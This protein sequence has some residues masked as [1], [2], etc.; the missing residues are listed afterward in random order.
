V[1]LVAESLDQ[2]AYHVGGEAVDK[3]PGTSGAK[4]ALDQRSVV[5]VQQGAAIGE[6]QDGGELALVDRGVPE[7]PCDLGEALPLQPGVVA[8]PGSHD[9]A[10]LRDRGASELELALQ[11]V[12]PASGPL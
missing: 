5:G 9:N 3:R 12:L 1:Q 8:P 7:G 2:A 4:H 11:V 10:R 6:K